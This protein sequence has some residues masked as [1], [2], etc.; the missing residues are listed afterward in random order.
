MA[1]RWS[2]R[3]THDSF[4]RQE[5]GGAPMWFLALAVL[6]IAVFGAI[7]V[8]SMLSQSPAEARPQQPVPTFTYGSDATVIPTIAVVGDSNTEVD[9]P[10][11]ASGNIGTGSW[12]YQLTSTGKFKFNG[13]WADGGTTSTTQAE[14]LAPVPQSDI[15]L[16]MTGTN[17]LGQGVPFDQTTANIDAMV[18]K[19]PASKVVLLAIPPRDDETSPTSVEYNSALAGLAASRG[20]EFFDGLAF[21]RAPEGG[22]VDGATSDGVH[23]TR[24]SYIQYGQAVLDHLTT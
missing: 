15:L 5:Y 8:N 18:A 11:F 10:D 9:S 21:L 23:L 6:A 13:G 1:K 17:D 3:S 4:W 2:S 16:I 7:G 19:A 22:F 12:V 14:S 24:D 20:W